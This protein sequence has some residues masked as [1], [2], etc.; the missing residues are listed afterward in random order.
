MD[1]TL[2]AVGGEPTPAATN[3][4]EARPGPDVECGPHPLQLVVR[5]VLERF[6]VP[7]EQALGV[8]MVPAVQEREI[9]IVPEQVMVLDG[10]QV[11]DH[12]RDEQLGSQAEELVQPDLEVEEGHE[13]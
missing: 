11:G 2:G 8:E 5:R 12:R 1:A 9:E 10:A 4:Q 13:P 7:V 3:V 6:V